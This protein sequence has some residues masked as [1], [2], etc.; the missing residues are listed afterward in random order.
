MVH[1][2]QPADPDPS[3]LLWCRDDNLF[4]RNFQ[5]A[6]NSAKQ[7]KKSLGLYFNPGPSAPPADGTRE[8]EP[9]L[10]GPFCNLE[11]LITHIVVQGTTMDE[12]A[13]D[14]ESDEAPAS[15]KPKKLK[16]PK[17]SKPTSAPKISQAKPVATAPPEDSVQS[18]DL[19]RIPSPRKSR[20]LCNTPAKN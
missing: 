18:E 9:N 19:S 5:F 10:V 12:P 17:A 16:H 8:A 3:S 1:G 20:C 2:P 7:N 15:L 6:Q 4:K 11:G 14:V 13:E